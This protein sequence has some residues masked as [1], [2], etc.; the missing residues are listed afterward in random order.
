MRPDCDATFVQE[1]HLHKGP[2]RRF[3][4]SVITIPGALQIILFDLDWWAS[5]AA[6]VRT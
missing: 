2:E 5:V 4:I 6:F 1:S 3:D